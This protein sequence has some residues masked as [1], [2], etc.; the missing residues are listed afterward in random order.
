MT[1]RSLIGTELDQIPVNAMLGGLAY[2]SPENATIKNLD[3]RN[4]AEINAETTDTATD[5]FVY[6]TSKDS[7][8]GAWRQRTQHT[9]WYNETLNTATRGSRREFPAV[10]VIVAEATQLTIYDGDDPDLP[11]WMVFNT[12]SGN[13]IGGSSS[14]NA[15]T[16]LNGIMVTGASGYCMETRFISD[17]PLDWFT[18]QLYE[19]NGNIEQRNDT[20]GFTLIESYG[21][22]DS[23][24]NDVAMTVLPRAPID[25]DTGLQVPTIAIGTDEGVSVIKD[26]GN[27]VD[28]TATSYDYTSSISFTEDNEL[29]FSWDSNTRA[30]FIHVYDIPSSDV[31]HGGVGYQ[32]GAG[33]RFYTN[34]GPVSKDLVIWSNTSTSW[35]TS[36]VLSNAIGHSEGLTL[37]DENPASP[38]NG[39]VA[40]ATTSYKLDIW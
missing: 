27:V 29:I 9:S 22:V 24:I 19:Y 1:S 10:A 2:Q 21:I 18:N 39:M 3:L 31:S 6:D 20:L 17:Y 12:T 23:D 7:D 15:V 14:L 16:A 25:P 8:G 30:R 28:I 40:Y 32:Y 38:A 37:L 5:V 4:I 34:Y 11:M 36:E 33:K 35:N 26:D 13:L